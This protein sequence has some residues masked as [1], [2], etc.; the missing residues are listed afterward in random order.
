MA[1][2]VYVGETLITVTATGC[3]D[4]GGIMDVGSRIARTLV[5]LI[6]DC[7]ELVVVDVYRCARCANTHQTHTEYTPHANP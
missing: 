5:V 3:I 7:A 6:E 2:Q 1:D 4:C